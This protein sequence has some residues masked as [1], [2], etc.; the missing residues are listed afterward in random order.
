[1]T[2]V[3]FEQLVKWFSEPPKGPAPISY[4]EWKLLDM[5]IR[6]EIIRIANRCKHEMER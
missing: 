2:V 6:T 4:E 1:M 3:G 5:K